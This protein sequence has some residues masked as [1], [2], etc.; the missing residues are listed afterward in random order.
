[1]NHLN[2]LSDW[3]IGVSVDV[4][5]SLLMCIGGFVCLLMC[6]G[7]FVC[8]LMCI[9]GFVRLLMCIGGFVDVQYRCIQAGI[10]VPWGTFNPMLSF[11]LVTQNVVNICMICSQYLSSLLCPKAVMFNNSMPINTWR[12]IA[13][14]V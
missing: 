5:W 11:T 8:L 13:T 9:G 12:H 14:Q 1:M 6:I 2:I 10:M 4:N 7:G 3:R